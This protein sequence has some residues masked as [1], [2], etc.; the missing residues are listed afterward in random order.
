MKIFAYL[1]LHMPAKKIRGN[2]IGMNQHFKLTKMR[3]CRTSYFVLC[4]VRWMKTKRKNWNVS[5]SATENIKRATT[6][7]TRWIK[8]IP[9][10]V[11]HEREMHLPFLLQGAWQM[12]AKNL[13]H[14][15][16]FTSFSTYR[17][18][19]L[20][21]LRFEIYQLFSVLCNH[22]SAAILL[23]CRWQQTTML[24]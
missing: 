3:T 20:S 16:G 2:S 24:S 1:Q 23:L 8:R 7:T 5:S 9:Y 12:E 10:A 21:H 15:A 13:N 19:P 22:L 17:S 18:P 11:Q 14:L 4:I 6:Q